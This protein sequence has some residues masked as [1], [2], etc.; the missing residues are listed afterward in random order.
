MKNLS[1]KMKNLLKKIPYIKHL[2]SSIL[3]LQERLNYLEAELKKYKTTF[4]PGHYYSPIPSQIDIQNNLN[5][6]TDDNK[7]QFNNININDNELLL[8]LEKFSL[9]YKDIPFSHEKKET[10]RYYYNNQMF[11]E[12][13]AIILYSFI[14]HFNPKKI[15][16]VGS[17]F[18]SAIFLDTLERFSNQ[19]AEII[20][21][22]PYPERLKLLLKTTDNIVLHQKK[23]QEINIEEFLKLEE[24]DILFID[25]TH[26]SKFASDVNY[27]FFKILPVLKKGV[28]IHIHDIFFNFEY[29]ANWLQ[30]GRAWNEAYLLKA[31]LLYNTSF[32][33]LMF[34]SYIGKYYE[35][36]MFE[37][38]PLFMKNAGGSIWLKK[39]K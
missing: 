1:K 33:I 22:E 39:T 10:I 26:V 34:N 20:F 38:F 27:L 2:N 23:L 14:R 24:N 3:L 32:E 35:T 13:D 17:G 29:P 12:G 25:S 28:I 9:F 21:I 30:E 19:Q 8:L 6:I 16:E 31:F 37:K 7:I 36:F 15:I 18:S 11:C 4:P 5:F